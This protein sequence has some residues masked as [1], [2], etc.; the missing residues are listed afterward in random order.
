MINVSRAAYPDYK[1]FAAVSNGVGRHRDNGPHAFVE[2]L[3]IGSLRYVAR[4][5]RK[6]QFERLDAKWRRTYARIVVA[7]SGASTAGTI[8]AAIGTAA[9]HRG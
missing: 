2:S 5:S 7:I 3:G 1:G 6:K 4:H 9:T 8:G